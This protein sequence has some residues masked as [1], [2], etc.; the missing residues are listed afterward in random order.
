[1]NF[2]DYVRQLQADSDYRGQVA[3]VEL[4]ARRSAE[5]ASPVE[6][7]LPELEVKLRELGVERLYTHQAQALDAVRGGNDV[8]VVTATASGKTLCY[9]LPAIEAVL[10]DPRA[11]ALYL[12]PTKALAQDQLGKLN[13]FGLFPTVRFATFDGD[14]AQEDR[15]YIKRAAHIVLSNPD[16]LHV[17]MLPYHTTWAQFFTNLR[18][19][20]LDEIHTYRGVFGAHVAQVI[21]RLRRVCAHYGADPQFIACSATIANPAEL[22]ESITG[23]RATVIDSDGSPSGRRTFVFWNP[24]LVGN[25]GGRRSAHVEATNLFTGL[26][27]SDVRTLTFAK[28]RKSAELILKYSRE[29]L[30]RQESELAGRI[31][32]YRAGYTPTERR[33]IERGLFEGKLLGVTATNAL[34][35][36]VDVGTLDATVLTGYPGTIASAW[37]QAG[38]SGRSTGEAL[39]VLIALDNPLDQYFMRHPEYFFGRPTERAIVDPHNKRILAGHLECAAYELPLAEQ[40][41]ELFSPRAPEVIDQLE[42]ERTLV[43]RNGKWYYRGDAYPAGAVNIRSASGEN[44]QIRDLGRNRMVIGSVEGARAYHTIHQGAI[45]LHQGET[46]RVAELDDKE[47]AAYVAA[48]DANYYTEPRETTHIAVAKEIA[49]A[50]LG[51]TTAYFGEVVVSNQV[52]G[53]RCKQLYSDTVLDVVDLDLPE[54]VFETEAFWFTI[55]IPIMQEILRKGLDFCGAIHAAEH[56]AIGMMPLLSTCDR[57]DIGGVSTPNHPDTEMATIFIYD[58]YPGGVGIAQATFERLGELLQ[59]TQDLIASCPCADGCPSCVQSP[60]CGN[61]NE[62]LDKAGAAF[63]LKEI[64]AGQPAPMLLEERIA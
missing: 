13:D 14:T 17:G 27:A 41:L 3:H 18:Y 22:M 40:E 31:M 21:R 11:R 32:S 46:Y 58:G 60:K 34:E 45:Y 35:L 43:R 16:M 4:I 26:V 38:R 55:P 42:E 20:V 52:L 51:G 48:T 15:R 61:N 10:K 63:L 50:P 54:Q 8:I 39:S 1:M 59:V 57:W 33:A 64:L 7:L 30:D 9:N 5:Y 6:P 24:P 25:D 36:G 56:A 23:V 28:A 12:F 44:Y 49:S 47:H 62:P 29:E 2:A 53:Y 37:Q 19:V